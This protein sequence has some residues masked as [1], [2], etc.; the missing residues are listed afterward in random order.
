MNKAVVNEVRS[1]IIPLMTCRLL[2]PNVVVAEVIDY[3]PPIPKDNAPAWLLGDLKWRGKTIPLVSVEGIMGGT[4]AGASLRSRIIVMNTLNDV[5][6]LSH[7][8][9][10][11]QTIPT[12]VRVTAENIEPAKLTGN[13]GRMVKQPVTI[14]AGLALIPDL[15]ALE[16]QV[17]ETLNPGSA[18]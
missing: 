5:K 2:L 13:L 6:S 8:A 11:T 10:I 12:L 1:V 9:L 7:I 4:V 16:N 14:N 3:Q 18:A 15:D 17:R